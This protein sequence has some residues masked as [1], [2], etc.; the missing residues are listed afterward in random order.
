[1]RQD[2]LSCWE[3]ISSGGQNNPIKPLIKTSMDTKEKLFLRKKNLQRISAFFSHGYS[4]EQS[5][6]CIPMSTNWLKN[7]KETPVGHGR[8]RPS[9]AKLSAHSL[10]Q[11]Q[12][13]HALVHF[14]PFQGWFC[15]EGN[16][17]IKVLPGFM[18][19]YI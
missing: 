1:M 12:T 9:E 5:L 8:S 4:N 10:K 15:N 13:P 16:H 19:F 17:K 18:T 6:P 2:V 7:L 14:C 11:T 3:Y